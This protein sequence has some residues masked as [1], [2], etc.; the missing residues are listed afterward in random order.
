MAQIL[1]IDGSSLKLEDIADVAR[2]TGVRVELAPGAVAGVERSRAAVEEL[3]RRGEVAY[4][5]TT[6]FGAFARTL[7]APEQAAALQRN[8]LVSHATGVGP[9]LPEAA[10]RATILIRANSLAK[11]F[12]GIRR[13]T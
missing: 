4:G 12:S 13:E 11:G 8:I 3:L 2:G 7:I 9:P 1:Q 6:G 10:V 5:I